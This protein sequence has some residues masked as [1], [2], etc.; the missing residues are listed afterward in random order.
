MTKET[1]TITFDDFAAH[2]PALFDLMAREDEAVLVEKG[3]R[4]YRVE[5]TAEV[6]DPSPPAHD[7]SDVRRML[8]RTAGGF[9]GIDRAAIMKDIH[10]GRAQADRR[11]PA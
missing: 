2:L 11:P 1:R 6:A 7:P 9:K 10:A 5:P 4:L 8:A 3:G